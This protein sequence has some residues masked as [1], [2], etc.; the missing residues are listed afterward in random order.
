MLVDELLPALAADGLATGR[1]GLL[2]I[3][4]G[5]HGALLLGGRLGTQRV[6]AVGALSP[7]LWTDASAAAAGAFDSPDDFR[8]NDPFAVR[9][10][11][12]GI[13]TRLDTGRDD[14]FADATRA[15]LASAPASVA[16][17]LADGCHDAAFWRRHAGAHLALVATGLAG[18]A[19]AG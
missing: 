4:M 11:L 12:A 19:P 10:G 15:F 2:G 6:A 17:G 3:S 5:G 13:P 9:D 18:V 7:A 16:G 8:A 14:P 1:I